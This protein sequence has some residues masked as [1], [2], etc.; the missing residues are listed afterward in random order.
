MIYL[1]I[2]VSQ[3]NNLYTLKNKI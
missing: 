1:Y 2:Q 3:E